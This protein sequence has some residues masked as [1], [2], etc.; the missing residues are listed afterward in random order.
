MASR[1]KI[2]P[3]PFF[4]MPAARSLQNVASYRLGK[5]IELFIARGSVVDFA[6]KHGAIVNAANEGCLYGGG[7]DGAISDA[8]GHTLAA[9][10]IELPL[11]APGCRCPTGQA[12][13]SGPGRYG[14]LRVP[15]VIHAVGPA[16]F[17]YETHEE[18]DQ[19]L[20]SAYYETLELC[21]ASPIQ[22][23]AFSLL[24]SGGFRGDRGLKSVLR[25]GVSGI[26]DWVDGSKNV[27]QLQS[28]TLCAFSPREID[29]LLSVCYEELS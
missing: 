24:S 9:D 7:V 22:D 6:S 2:N 17:A 15:Y 10:R 23:V 18:A 20:Q 16:Y 1:S 14:Q 13:L 3:F 29:V 19:L 25:L 21:R 28:V 26:R 11:V 12:R 27:G 5:N 4:N 8:G